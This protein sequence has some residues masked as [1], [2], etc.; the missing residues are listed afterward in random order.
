MA[1]AYNRLKMHSE[2]EK[3]YKKCLKINPKDAH[4]HYNLAILYDD[5]LNR[6]NKAIKHYKKYIQLHPT[7]E[8][9]NQVKE[10][11]LYAEQEVRLGS[12]SR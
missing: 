9:V 8:G 4:V 7:G 12:Q 5:K 11:L 1:I 3:E 2:E 10:W 6:K